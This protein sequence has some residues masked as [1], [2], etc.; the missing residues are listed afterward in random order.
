MAVMLGYLHNG[1]GG[2]PTRHAD[3]ESVKGLFLECLDG[4]VDLSFLVIVGNG[5]DR[6]QVKTLCLQCGLGGCALS[7]NGTD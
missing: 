5:I 1:M 2:D 6:N 7:D 4:I 3:H